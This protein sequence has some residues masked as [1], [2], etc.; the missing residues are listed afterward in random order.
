MGHAIRLTYFLRPYLADYLLSRFGPDGG[1]FCNGKLRR[2]EHPLLLYLNC[3]AG[4]NP[5]PLERVQQFARDRAPYTITI[6]ERRSRRS[7][8]ARR[9][10]ML[11][12][13]NFERLVFQQLMNELT[14]H[15]SAHK[16]HGVQ[17]IASVMDFMLIHGIS[18][19]HIDA[20]DLVRVVRDVQGRAEQNSAP[21]VPAGVRTAPAPSSR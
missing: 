10:S 12:L 17:T 3:T 21:S 13:F 1:N 7:G 14:A 5:P 6:S 20:E 8:Y 15:I 9:I 11:G 16:R 2:K 18:P 4:G 19:Y